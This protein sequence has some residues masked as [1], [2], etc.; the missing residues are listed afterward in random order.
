MV[1]HREGET[2]YKADTARAETRARHHWLLLALAASLGTAGFGAAA[3]AG[4][5]GAVCTGFCAPVPA[6]QLESTRGAGSDTQIGV[7][8]WDELRR[9]GAP[10]PPPTSN[11]GDDSITVHGPGSVILAGAKSH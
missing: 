5:P 11:G 1:M 6:K 2:E 9:Q 3:W 4:E 8:L 7:I 10:P